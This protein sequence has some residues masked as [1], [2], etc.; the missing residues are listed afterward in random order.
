ML[1]LDRD[2]ISF[3]LYE[4]SYRQ[5][6]WGH[7]PLTDFWRVGRGYAS[8]LESHGLFTMGDVARCSLTH[9]D[10]LYQLFGVN[11]ELLIDHAWGWEPCM[12]ADIKGYRPEANS[13][14]SGQVLH[15]PY[16]AEKARLVVREMTELLVLDLVEKRLVTDQMTLAIGYDVESLTDP[17]I[18]RHY[19]G[20]VTTDFYGRK[21]PKHAHGTVGLP[22][23]TSSARLITEAVMGLFDGIVHPMLLVRRI[24]IGAGRVVEE[25]AVAR[26]TVVE[27]LDLF[28]DHEAQEAQR[29]AEDAALKKERSMQETLVSLRSRFGRNTVLKGMSLQDG[30]TARQRNEQIGG[31]RA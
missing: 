15:C 23:P 9:E 4:L 6:L 24:T 3:G 22:R 18:A 31:H 5:Q 13:I 7:R 25:G 28:T 16:S 11:A 30:A 14:S 29:Q 12:M 17:K 2:L 27:Q 19:K 8:K 21:V 26:K 20:A 10:L 1:H